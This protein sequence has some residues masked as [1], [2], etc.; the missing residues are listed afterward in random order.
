M[1]VERQ[2]QPD[3]LVVGTEKGT[4]EERRRVQRRRAPRGGRREAD[5][6]ALTDA[7]GG[8]ISVAINRRKL[9]VTAV[10][11]HAGVSENTV[12]NVLA[13]HNTNVDSLFAI[14]SFLELDLPELFRR[15]GP[16]P[17]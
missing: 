12:R 1:E 11:V 15:A 4:D 5:A 3:S 17:Q 6:K 13:G 16:N 9:S 2:P 14:A 8:R 7:I 10:A